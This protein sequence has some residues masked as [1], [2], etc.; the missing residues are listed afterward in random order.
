MSPLVSTRAGISARSYGL[1]GALAVAG[2]FESIQ[3]YTLSSGT[4]QVEFSSIPSTYKHLQVRG[5]ILNAPTGDNVAIRLGNGSIDT[6]SNYA[7]HQIQG[8]GAS[9]TAAASTSQNAAYLSGLCQ[10]SSIYPF[11]F[12]YDILDYANTNKNK[13]IRGL[14]GQDGNGSG[15]ATAWRITF[16]SG[17][18]Q[19]TSAVTNLRIYL[20]AGNMGQYTQIAL[21][22]IKG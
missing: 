13:T 22:G 21:Y 4:A 10:A 6:G 5:I 1:F 12:V 11:A 9:V 20:P 16:T 2:D 19:S 7:S 15:T 3:T 18:W 8:D 14:S 17:L